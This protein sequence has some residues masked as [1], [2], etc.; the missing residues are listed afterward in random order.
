MV[1]LRSVD[2]TSCQAKDVTIE[3]VHAALKQTSLLD[4]IVSELLCI[5]LSQVSPAID[6][7]PHDQVVHHLST[8]PH[9]IF[10]H[11]L[12]Y[13]ACMCWCQHWWINIA[14]QCCPGWAIPAHVGVTL[15]LVELMQT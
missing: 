12:K 9:T 6:D 8:W 7:G 11:G 15:P 5:C 14:K 3:R 10:L 2:Y 13:A 1:A 4:A